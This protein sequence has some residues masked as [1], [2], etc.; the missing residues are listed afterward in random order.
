MTLKELLKKIADSFW[1][2]N[3][4]ETRV[5]NEST[6]GHGVL[7]GAK[8]IKN[9][10][11]LVRS[12][13]GFSYDYNKD[14]EEAKSQMFELKKNEMDRNA[15]GRFISHSLLNRI[16]RRWAKLNSFLLSRWAKKTG[17]DYD[18]EIENIYEEIDL[19]FSVSE[20]DL[21]QIY[22]SC[23]TENEV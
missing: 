16:T 14:L 8:S 10:A 17:F 1:W 3:P 4:A 12:Y 11:D 20:C 9:R 2:Q 5:E 7:L 18:E 13:G 6:G 21:E 19:E 22:F 23:V 15:F